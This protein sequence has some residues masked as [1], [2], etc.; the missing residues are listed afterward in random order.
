MTTP[1]PIASVSQYGPPEAV[2]QLR[3]RLIRRHWSRNVEG[4]AV[5]ALHEV[6]AIA[7]PGWSADKVMV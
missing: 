1:S 5:T 2:D 4:S 3:D 7:E 6:R